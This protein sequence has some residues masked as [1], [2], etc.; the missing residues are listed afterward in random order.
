[1]GAGKIPPPLCLRMCRSEYFLPFFFFLT[2]RGSFFQLHRCAVPQREVFDFILRPYLAEC[3]SSRG[4]LSSS[5]PTAG[6]RLLH[7]SCFSEPFFLLTS[8]HVLR[9]R[10]AW[11]PRLRAGAGTPGHS[12][13]AELRL[14]YLLPETTL[15]HLLPPFFDFFGPFM[16]HEYRSHFLHPC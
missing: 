8:P 12:L 11:R 1:L 10:S 7:E 3:F 4:L 15:T 9:K 6:M 5:P 13:R 2:L 14:G 16:K